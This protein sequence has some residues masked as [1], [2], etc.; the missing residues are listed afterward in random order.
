MTEHVV[1]LSLGSNIRPRANLRA[2]LQLLRAACR[3]ERCSPLY[4]AAARGDRNQPDFLNMALRARTRRQPADFH[5]AV[6]QAIERQL[7]RRRVP[8]NRNAARTIDIDIAL[9][10]AASL[11]FGEPPRQVPDP[12]ILRYA[13]VARPLAAL[14]PDYLHPLTG[15]SLRQIAEELGTAGIRQLKLDL[16][17]GSDE[18]SPQGRVQV[19]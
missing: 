19:Q 16:A 18:L 5:G 15:Q 11:E 3:V 12:D 8:G 17:Q 2:A 6:I 14:D 10:D 9:W 13:H 7:G 1:W 4:R